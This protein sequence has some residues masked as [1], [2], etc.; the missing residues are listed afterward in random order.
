[1][2]QVY[3]DNIIVEGEKKMVK[4]RAEDEPYDFS[5]INNQLK[6]KNFASGPVSFMN[7]YEL[8]GCYKDGFIVG[9]RVP[10]MSAISAYNYNFDLLATQK[11]DNMPYEVVDNES[12]NQFVKD[13]GTAEENCK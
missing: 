3:I 10:F 9:E 12:F 1:M 8:L 4:V 7:F 5:L 2:G 6:T 13:Y 11:F